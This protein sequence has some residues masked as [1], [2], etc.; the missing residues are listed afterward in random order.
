MRIKRQSYPIAPIDI[1]IADNGKFADIAFLVDRHDFMED[2]AKLRNSW[3]GKTLLD[4]NKINNFINLK[5]DIKAAKHFWK[6]YFELRRIAKRYNLGATYVGSILAATTSGKVTDMD[7]RTFLKEP[8]MYGLPEDLQLD[9]DVTFTSHR[10][11]EVDE[12][13]P[14]QDTKTISKVKRDREWYWLYQKIGYRK[15][16]KVANEQLTTV[17]SAINSYYS[18]LDSYHSVTK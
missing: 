16:A 7:Y 15:I 3:I 18:K 2:I 1:Q 9:D 17:V 11:R 10:V 13:A 6:H 8:I 12:I 14:I 4:Q 5:R